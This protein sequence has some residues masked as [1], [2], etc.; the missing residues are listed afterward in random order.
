MEH[1][2]Y[3]DAL[4]RTDVHAVIIC[5]EPASHADYIQQALERGKHVLVEYPVALSSAVTRR[6]YQTAADMGLVLQEENIALLTDQH[7]ELKKMAA[8]RQLQSAS[9]RLVGN[10]NGWV[11]Q[12][13]LDGQPF[14][15]SVGEIQTLYDVFGDLTPVAASMDVSDV[16]LKYSGTFTLKSG[17]GS[18]TIAVERSKT[19]VQRS[20]T[21]YVEFADG[22]VF[23]SV[24]EKADTQTGPK[25]P[26]L[27]MRDLEIFAAKLR[28]ERPVTESDVILS[29]HSLELAEEANTLIISQPTTV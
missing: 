9:T 19:K 26:G 23:D 17:P 11:E 8:G 22:Q 24:K 18:L 1:M 13:P 29:V 16:G 3:E 6:L 10:Y 14:Y 7:Q 27:F 15:S 28:G 4:S 20:S 2:Q 25:K 21:K 5:T 12:N